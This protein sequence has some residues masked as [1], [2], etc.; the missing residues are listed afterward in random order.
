MLGYV[1][2]QAEG[3]GDALI[4]TVTRTLAAEGV[5][6][7]AAV[8]V[9]RGA[10]A[11][12]RSHMDL[13]LLPAGTV[14]RISQ[15]LGPGATGCRLDPAALETA[16]GQL[17]AALAARP[18]IVIVNKFGKQELAGRGFR[19]LIGTALAEGIPVLVGVHAENRT[20]FETFAD[21]LGTAL[22]ADAPTVLAWCRDAATA[23]ANGD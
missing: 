12:R 17:D 5:P 14:I 9:N 21:G 11:M 10:G 23:T 2:T 3:D 15:D 13:E 18:G 6:L 7:A 22:A 8:Q 16:V 20:A 4:A 1:I 19:A